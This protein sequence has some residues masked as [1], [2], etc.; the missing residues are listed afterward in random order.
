MVK[1]FKG[2][3]QRYFFSTKTAVKTDKNIVSYVNDGKNTKKSFAS[4]LPDDYAPDY[5]TEDGKELNKE[6]VGA[7]EHV[8]NSNDSVIGIQG[9][10][11][12]G[13]TSLMRK[14]IDAI[15][16]SGKQTYVFAPSSEAAFDVLRKKEG[17]TNANT[18]QK[19]L[20]DSKEAADMREA[21]QNQAVWID[22]ASLLSSKQMNSLFDIAGKQNT[23]VY[24]LW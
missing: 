1:P 14:T 19:L 11:G 20:G 12:V 13:K 9:G 3:S 15:E 10:A 2:Q 23:R 7:V 6:Q 4:N 21:M 16:L 17:F 22:E 24:S 18:I 8:L 5:T